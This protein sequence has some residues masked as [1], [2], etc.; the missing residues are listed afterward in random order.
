MPPKNVLFFFCGIILGVMVAPQNKELDILNSQLGFEIYWSI[1]KAGQ[2]AYLAHFQA[3]PSDDEGIAK[4]AS[5][6]GGVTTNLNEAMGYIETCG[7][8]YGYTKLV[9]CDRRMTES[10]VRE[11]L[12]FLEVYT[13]FLNALSKDAE[14]W[15]SEQIAIMERANLIIEDRNEKTCL[16]EFYSRLQE[17][18]KILSD[19]ES[20]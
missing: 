1:E 15:T 19:L 16:S 4:F 8:Y 11:V 3:E 12:T 17:D 9:D 20:A 18:Q 14:Q 7:A 5:F 13:Q 10:Q 2:Y 6:M